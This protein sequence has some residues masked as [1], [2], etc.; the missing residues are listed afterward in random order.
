M[1][2]TSDKTVLCL[3]ASI[4]QGKVSSSF[5]DI[6]SQ[7]MDKDGFHFINEG[8]AGYQSYNILINLES[9]IDMRPDFIVILV[10]TND[11]TA[12]LNPGIAGLARLTNKTPKPPSAQLYHE[13]ML[14]IVKTLKEK[15]SAKIALVSIPPLGEDLDSQ[16]NG[17]IREYNEFLNEITNEEQVSYLPVYEKQEEYLKSNLQTT[18]RPFKG[19]IL[20]SLELLVRHFILG[21]SF[22]T[23][24]RKKGYLLLTD[25]IH[26]NSRG[27]AFIADEVES[28]LRM[29]M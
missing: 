7:R 23:I 25:G 5:V 19:G 16:P 27:A 24:S 14:Q 10:G 20:P 13:N 3:G 28:F 22:D 4:V 15:T 21:Q 17:R 2:E 12:A 6:L 9:A 11:V 1:S 8:V 29:N 26:M 18:G